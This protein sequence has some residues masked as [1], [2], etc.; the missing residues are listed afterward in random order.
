MLQSRAT[1]HH[2][3]AVIFSSFSTGE[4]TSLNVNKRLLSQS[5][6]LAANLAFHQ[7]Q[8]A[9]CFSFS[10]L[11]C[12]CLTGGRRFP[13][14]FLVHHLMPFHVVHDFIEPCDT[15][16]LAPWRLCTSY[17]TQDTTSTSVYVTKHQ[18]QVATSHLYI[19]VS[20]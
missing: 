14:C 3:M 18:K 11:Q 17:D 12:S 4:E 19:K 13:D 6:P 5:P 20:E 1:D 9:R 7:M 2:D 8:P 10:L 16:L 15:L